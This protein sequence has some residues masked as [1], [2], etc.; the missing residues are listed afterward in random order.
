VCALLNVACLSLE[1]SLEFLTFQGKGRKTFALVACFGFRRRSNL[2]AA[3]SGGHK[4]SKADLAWGQVGL[5][6]SDDVVC[7][8]VEA[9]LVAR[10]TPRG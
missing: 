10:R 2:S 5:P 8:R 7:T 9:G 6:V 3:L 1:K 4:A